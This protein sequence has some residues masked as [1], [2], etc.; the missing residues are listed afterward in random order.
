MTPV[1]MYKFDLEEIP[2]IEMTYK[3]CGPHPRSYW[4]AKSE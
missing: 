1:K 2:N 3:K 4:R